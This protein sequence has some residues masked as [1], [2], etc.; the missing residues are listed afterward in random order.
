M[1]REIKNILEGNCLMFGQLVNFNKFAA[2]FSEG[3]CRL[4]SRELIRILGVRLMNDDEK[5]LGNPIVRKKN[6][7]NNSQSLIS[8]VK[9]RI[10]SW[11]AHL[12]Y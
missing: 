3:T 1:V 4:R 8:K 5:Y 7:N 10:M 6:K 2:Y 11:P 9:C 12:L